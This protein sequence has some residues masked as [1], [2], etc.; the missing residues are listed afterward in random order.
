MSY[1]QATQNLSCKLKAEVTIFA[2]SKF[3]NRLYKAFNSQSIAF[4]DNSD[5]LEFQLDKERRPQ[6]IF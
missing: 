2:N 6:R 5:E 1:K 3:N 4:P